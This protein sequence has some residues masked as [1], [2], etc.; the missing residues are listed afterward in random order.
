VAQEG[1]DLFRIGNL[2]YLVHE[3]G[4]DR[5]WMVGPPGY[6][7]VAEWVAQGVSIEY[8]AAIARVEHTPGSQGV[9]LHAEAGGGG[10]PRAPQ[11][12]RA[13]CRGLRMMMGSA[14]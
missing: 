13:R 4:D 9:T 2:Q 3:Y 7:A 5:E 12:G 14:T 1:D 11:Y 10:G 8:G 6:V